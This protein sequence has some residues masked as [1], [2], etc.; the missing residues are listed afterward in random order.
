M[1]FAAMFGDDAASFVITLLITFFAVVPA[2]VL[3]ELAHGLV[4]LWNG[5]P[6][7]KFSG[8]LTLN[9]LKHLDPVGFVMMML[10]GFG[11]AK[12]VPVNP[13]NFKKFRRGLIT[14][15]AAGIIMN[16]LVAFVSSFF[17]VLFSFV[18]YRVG[19][20]AAY[21]VC[22]YLS[23]YFL[24]FMTVNLSLAFFNLLPFYPL[25]GFR[26]IES[27][28]HQGNRFVRFMRNNGQ[29]ILWGLMGLSFIVSMASNY[30]A[31]LPY[32]FSYFDILGTYIDFFT[33]HVS[34]GFTSLWRL[35]L[36]S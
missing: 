17:C 29:Y 26:L 16:V 31:S 33:S 27:L 25:D 22:F 3:H 28:T 12:P 7:A 34:F 13:Y 32:W 4:A 8:R 14:V 23:Q 9:P 21:W 36:P 35:M 24:I 18:S 5:D 11:Y 20:E 2:L 1:I 19:S 10:V 6:T 30:A 15:S